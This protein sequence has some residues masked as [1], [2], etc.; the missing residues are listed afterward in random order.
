MFKYFTILG[1]ILCLAFTIFNNETE[2]QKVVITCKNG[3]V[4]GFNNTN[5]FIDSTN[6]IYKFN[7]EGSG[8]EKI[9]PML[10]L[11]KNKQIKDI[12][13]ISKAIIVSKSY[14]DTLLKFEN[15]RVRLISKDIYNY[16]IN[17]NRNK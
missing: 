9:E 12:L 14:N 1:I 2:P 5:I 16:S 17:I 8:Y 10:Y 11:E 6:G 4:N 15:Y 3:G 13:K 7:F